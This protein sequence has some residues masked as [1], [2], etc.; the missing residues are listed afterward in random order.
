MN[1]TRLQPGASGGLDEKADD[2][3]KQVRALHGHPIGK[4]LPHFKPVAV[5]FIRWHREPS[6]GGVSRRP[7]L[8]L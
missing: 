8:P 3:T 5:E 6:L 1:E 4:P 2:T 7:A